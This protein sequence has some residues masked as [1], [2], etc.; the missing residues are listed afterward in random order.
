VQRRT[1]SGTLSYMSKMEDIR[2]AEQK[3]LRILDAFKNP[4]AEVVKLSA[5]L[6]DTI[7]E[8]ARAIRGLK[9]STRNGLT[10]VC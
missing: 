8:H 2:A 3:L 5:E 10:F 1:A 4:S 9:F 7:A 6:D